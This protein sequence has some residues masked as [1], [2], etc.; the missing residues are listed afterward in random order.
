MSP[1]EAGRAIDHLGINY[2]KGLSNH[3]A[4]STC[5]LDDMNFLRTV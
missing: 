4:I 5:P 1:L 2:L 3:I